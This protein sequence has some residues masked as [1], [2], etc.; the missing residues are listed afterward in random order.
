MFKE[1]IDIRKD[2]FEVRVNQYLLAPRHRKN[3]FLSKRIAM[4]AAILYSWRISYTL[5]LIHD[6]TVRFS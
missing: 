1:K 5:L 3:N 6:K 4:L 2:K